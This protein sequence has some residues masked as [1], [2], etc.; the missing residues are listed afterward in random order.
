MPEP[1]KNE[2]R[3]DALLARLVE[4]T[5]TSEEF[6]ELESLLDRNEDAQRRY[7]H[8]LG[9][10][11]DMQEPGLPATAGTKSSSMARRWSSGALLAAAAVIGVLLV[12]IALLPKPDP[13]T[14]GL[15]DA[16]A[17]KPI[18]RIVELNGSVS[19][20]GDGGQLTHDLDV[21]D[22]LGGGTLE[23]M[24]QNS[25]AEIEFLDGSRI[26]V[27]GPT[28]L[29]LS[30]G[31]EGKL[32]RLRHGELSAEVRP[33]SAGKPF[34]LET[35]S[36]ELEVVGTRFN[37]VANSSSTR[38]SVN[39]GLLQ[40]RRLADGESREVPADHRVA[41]ALERGTDFEV[42]PR[43]RHVESW[44][45]ELPGDL[46]YGDWS[47]DGD[48]GVL[49]AKPLLWTQDR[50]HP[51]LLHVASLHPAASHFS[52]V[53]LTEKARLR[54]RG[55]LDRDHAVGFGL[56]TLY[57]E[58]GFAGK[59]SIYQ[60]VSIDRDLGGVFDLTLPLAAFK[61]EKGCF[62]ASPVGHELFDC[63]ILT[64]EEDAGLE[65]NRVELLKEQ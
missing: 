38:V 22:A 32:V 64:I 10:H 11:A 8:Y 21:G 34:R 52:P 28:A 60:E 18:A 58:G 9:V 31:N 46:R 39:E 24:A 50:Q 6:E 26:R 2:K 1:N 51:I 29:T 65:I 25:W 17:P 45:S 16:P 59:Y 44:A 48:S 27:S 57:P 20:T 14:P 42:A 56:T 54:I 3:L 62:P 13:K 19:W 37:V 33:Q 35:S 47:A 49:K 7:L 15:V 4:A 53:R 63:W 61:P 41:V 55:R 43:R 23:A 40:V 36:A 5:I 30:E 12:A